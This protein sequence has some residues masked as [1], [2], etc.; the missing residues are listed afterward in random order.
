[1]NQY[2]NSMKILQNIWVAS[3]LL[4]GMCACNEDDI[5]TTPAVSFKETTISVEENAKELKVPLLITGSL[6]KTGWVFVSIIEGSEKGGERGINYTVPGYISLGEDAVRGNYTLTIIDDEY[7]NDDRTF[8]L[9]IKDVTGGAI[10][11]TSNQTC[12][13]TIVDDDSKKFV[14]VGFDSTRMDVNEDISIVEI[15]VSVKGLLSDSLFFEVETENGTALAGIDFELLES[16]IKIMEREAWGTVQIRIIDAEAQKEDRTFKLKIKSVEGATEQ[17]T[18]VAIRSNAAECEVTIKKVIREVRFA[19]TDLKIVEGLKPFEFP[20]ILTAP[21]T[22]DVNITIAVREGGSAIEGEHFTIDTK[23][24]VIKRGETVANAIITIPNDRLGRPVR[25]CEFEIISQTEGVNL[26]ETAKIARLTIEDDDASIGFGTPLLGVFSYQTARIPV[27]LSGVKGSRVLVNVAAKANSQIQENVHYMIMNKAVEIPE[28]DSVA[29]VQ[30]ATL[31]PTGFEEFTCELEITNVK[32][33]SLGA[34]IILENAAKDCSLEVAKVRDI[35][36]SNWEI[37]YFSTEEAVYDGPAVATNIID[38]NT[39]T[40]WHTQWMGEGANPKGPHTIIINTQ[41][42]LVSEV[43]ILY[44]NGDTQYT[45]I[46]FSDDQKT[47]K[48]LADSI[49]NP[50]SR[51]G[52][53]AVPASVSG[54]YMKLF[55]TGRANDGVASIKEVYMKGNRIGK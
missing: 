6:Q 43:S 10:K 38:N 30:V 8:T 54:H 20:I 40:F 13:V 27:V 37:T 45:N 49:P 42:T 18:T 36:R 35:D 51:T 17:D 55:V 14:S 29:Y 24:F 22:Q 46:S 16:R 2:P 48:E 15:P 41:N 23:E 26:S 19:E 25:Y 31:C 50:S 44:R 47:W 39:N 4:L 21:I 5:N 9:E 12:T 52:V 11:G 53:L 7:P 33:L 3:V 32:G 34:N 1:M 28:G